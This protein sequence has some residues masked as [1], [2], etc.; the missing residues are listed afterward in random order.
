MKRRVI[1][2]TSFLVSLSPLACDIAFTVKK[3][4]QLKHSRVVP[5]YPEGTELMIYETERIFKNTKTC[6]GI[7]VLSEKRTGGYETR[8]GHG[9]G[10]TY[11]TLNLTNGD[12]V[13]STTYTSA[14]ADKYGLTEATG[15]IVIT[16]GTGKYKNISGR[17][18]IHGKFGDLD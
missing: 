1:T 9:K 6:E 2:M 13:Y 8:H 7:E 5:D 11:S 10:K 4:Q 16:G 17:G 3:T 12:K 14:V 15:A 18:R